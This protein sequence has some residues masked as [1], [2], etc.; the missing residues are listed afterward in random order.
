MRILFVVGDIDH[1]R[2]PEL[3]QGFVGAVRSA[4]R[5][6]IGFDALLRGGDGGDQH[7][8]HPALCDRTRALRR[9]DPGPQRRMRNLH[10]LQ[11]HRNIVVDEMA[12]FVVEHLL[13]QPEQDDVERLL[14]QRAR[15]HRVDA[16]IGQLEDR[17]APSDAELEAA[18]AEMIQHADFPDQ[19]QRI[20]ERQQIDQWSEADALG[21][22]RDGGQEDPGDGAMPSGVA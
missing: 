12:S 6:H 9:V 11:L 14:E 15:M 8:I 7:R 22:L 2:K 3:R 4:K 21:A 19:A 16:M 17:D 18:A 20:V 1:A 5:A 10:G 13:A